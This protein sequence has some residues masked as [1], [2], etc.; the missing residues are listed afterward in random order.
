MP[1]KSVSWA[2]ISDRVM[3]PAPA[4]LSQV[5]SRLAKQF[6]SIVDLKGVTLTVKRDQPR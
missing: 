6:S 4:R 3:L 2:V 5:L 1:R